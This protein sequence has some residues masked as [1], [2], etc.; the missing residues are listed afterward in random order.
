MQKRDEPKKDARRMQFGCDLI[1][2]RGARKGRG[3]VSAPHIHKD[4]GRGGRGLPER[5]DK[6]DLG[7]QCLSLCDWKRQV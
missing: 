7:L 1:K 3:V 5:W 2:K 4:G 6:A